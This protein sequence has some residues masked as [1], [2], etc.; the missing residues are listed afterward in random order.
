M[1]RL[2]WILEWINK[3]YRDYEEARFE[4]ECAKAERD[5]VLGLLETGETQ[6]IPERFVEQQ[7][8]LGRPIEVRPGRNMPPGGLGTIHQR[9]EE[10]K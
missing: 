8:R 10:M 9:D 7:K 1:T 2:E 3:P 4:Y 5:M 6:R